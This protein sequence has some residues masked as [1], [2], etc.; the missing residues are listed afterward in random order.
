VLKVDLALCFVLTIRIL[1]VSAT[2]ILRILKQHVWTIVGQLQA[3][4]M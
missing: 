1:T 3:K 2:K 4:Y